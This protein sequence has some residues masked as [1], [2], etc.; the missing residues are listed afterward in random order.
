MYAELKDLVGYAECTLSLARCDLLGA[1]II[2]A[3]VFTTAC[4]GA[5]PTGSISGPAM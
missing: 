3:V 4:V 5:S 2:S 1:I